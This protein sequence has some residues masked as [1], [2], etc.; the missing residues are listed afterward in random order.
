MRDVITGKHHRMLEALPSS[1]GICIYN[2]WSEANVNKQNTENSEKKSGYFPKEILQMLHKA[3]PFCL[4][5]LKYIILYHNPIGIARVF[6][7]KFI[8]SEEKLKNGCKTADIPLYFAFCIPHFPNSPQ[9]AL[10]IAD[11]AWYNNTLVIHS[12]GGIFHVFLQDRYKMR[13]VGLR[14]RKRRAPRAAHRAKHHLQ[15]LRR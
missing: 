11:Q 14:A 9:K 8:K 1:F 13:T 12:Q 15:I 7:R 3:I 5:A 2:F 10:A 6:P 4:I